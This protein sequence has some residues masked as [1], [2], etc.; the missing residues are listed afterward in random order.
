MLIERLFFIFA[1][2]RKGA[3]LREVSSGSRDVLGNTD[4]LDVRIPFGGT[5]PKGCGTAA[6][7]RTQEGEENEEISHS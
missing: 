4:E 5:A 6:T 3:Q 1:V 2:Q 7:K